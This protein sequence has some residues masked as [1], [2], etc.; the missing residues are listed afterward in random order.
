MR[1]GRWVAGA[2]L[3]AGRGVIRA[4]PR[5]ALVPLVVRSDLVNLLL[6]ARVDLVELCGRGHSAWARACCAP[7]L[8]GGRPRTILW[9]SSCS[10]LSRLVPSLTS[11]SGR[12]LTMP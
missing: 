8:L 5:R 9:K 10:P 2:L 3:Q 12:R 1:M 4:D 7:A 11:S 6:L